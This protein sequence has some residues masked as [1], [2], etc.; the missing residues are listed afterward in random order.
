MSVKRIILAFA[1][2]ASGLMLRAQNVS[3][4]IISEALAQPDSSG[5]VDGYGRRCG[6]IELYNTST[7]TVNFGGCFLTDDRNNLRKS[8]IPKSD[9]RTKLGP[10]QVVL[11]HASGRS[12]DGT[13]YAGFTLAP[14]SCVYLVSNDGRSIIDSLKIPET[15]PCGKSVIKLADDIRQR[16]FKPVDTPAEPSPG[17]VNGHLASSTK[18][19][20]MSEQDPHGWTLSI[21]SVSVV[22]SALAILWLLFWLLFERP[23][24]RS[25]SPKARASEAP[26]AEVAAA[27]AAALD[28][29]C[30]GEEYAAIAAA[31]HIHFSSS[32][33]DTEPG[34]VTIKRAAQ[35]AWSDKRL[36]FRKLPK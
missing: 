32:V 10:R 30:S 34:I 20:Q 6:W 22:F 28:M 36:N 18:A 19:Q 2:L 33:H 15:I 29:E 31:L 8:L 27:I 25:A 13:F 7:G 11:F 9:N 17:I 14:G 24:K 4:L 1:A 3:D 35:S 16:E 21:V 26:D 12:E 5:I 23:A